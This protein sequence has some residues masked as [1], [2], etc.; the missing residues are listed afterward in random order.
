MMAAMSG[1]PMLSRPAFRTSKRRSSFFAAGPSIEPVADMLGIGIGEVVRGHR[2]RRAEEGDADRLRLTRESHGAAA[3]SVGVGHESDGC[4]GVGQE[5]EARPRTA[6]G[7]II[8]VDLARRVLEI[9]MRAGIGTDEDAVPGLEHVGPA[10]AVG[11]AARLDPPHQ[12]DSIG[13]RRPPVRQWRRILGKPAALH[14]LRQGDPIEVRQRGTRLLGLQPADHCLGRRGAEHDGDQDQESV[15]QHGGHGQPV[16][17]SDQMTPDG[18]A[19]G[20]VHA[21]ML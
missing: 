7:W 17:M 18:R 10:G 16:S 14:T 2:R 11:Y 4:R 20:H 6:I 13:R 15:L 19:C 12:F 8:D 5:A 1:E 3:K 21:G 9:G